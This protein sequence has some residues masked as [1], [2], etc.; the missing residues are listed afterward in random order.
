MMRNGVEMP[1]SIKPHTVFRK[2]SL[3]I[4][5]KSGIIV[6]T[7]GTIMAI[8]RTPNRKSFFLSW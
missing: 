1:G 4:I 6:A 3:D 8:R 2:P 7:P 5:L